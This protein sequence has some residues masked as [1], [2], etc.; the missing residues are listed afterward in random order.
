MSIFNLFFLES[1][2]KFNKV[3]IPI[4]K[5][6]FVK[7]NTL[8]SANARNKMAG[9]KFLN[10]LKD[11][12]VSACFFDP[13]YRGILDKMKYGNEGKNRGQA[14]ASLKQM[15]VATIIKFIREINRVLKASGHLFL[16]IDKFHLCSG[17]NSWTDETDLET[18]D[19]I[20]WD[21]DKMGMGYR[22]RRQSEHLVVLQKKPKRSKGVWTVKNIPDV[23]REK[24]V[25]KTHTHSKPIRLQVELITAVT[26]KKDWVID[27][28][29]GGFSVLEACQLAGRN[30]LGCDIN[31]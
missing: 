8:F 11:E 7:K 2:Y 23:W 28:A 3:K 18:V 12:S 26:S 22:S 19:M 29:G 13:Q 16:W 14:R 20:T 5:N 31:G 24:I 1:E 30:F 6:E 21:K 10:L 25:K 27:P 9:L 17:F 15:D 4:I